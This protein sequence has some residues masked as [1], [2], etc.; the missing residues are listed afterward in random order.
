MIKK[1][2]ATI[3][4]REFSM[5]T[6][7]VA[8]QAS[9]AVW[10][11]MGET[12]VLVTAVGDQGVREGIDFL[13]L[14]VDYQEMSYAAGR[15][16]GNFFRREMGRPSEK[17]TLTSRL[18]DRPVRPRMPKGWTHETQIIATV[19]SVDKVNEPDVM[20]L[21]GA[22][23]ALMISDV[24]FDGPLAGVRV[25]RVDGKLVVNPTSQEIEQSDM[26]FIVAGS[27][28]AIV[29][30]EG[31]GEQLTEEDVLEALWFGHCEMQPL[32][33]IQEELAAAVG[34][35]KR[36]YAKPAEPEGGLLEKVRALVAG[37]LTEILATAPKLERY[38]KVRA[39]KKKAAETLAE[40][41]PG[42]EG[43]I[44]NM[45][46]D[47]IAHDMREMILTEGRRVDG[48][49]HNQVRPI[50][51]EVGVL[52]RAHGS[53]LFTR[54]ET[55]AVVVATLGT[56]GDE[57]R[58]ESVTEGDTFRHFLLH[59]NFPPYCVGEAKMLRGPGRRE[60]GHGALARRALERV[61]PKR[62]D[63]PYSIRVVSEI[64]E[65]NGSS[66]MATVCGGSMALMD[67][68][69]PSRAA[70]AGVA[71]GLIKEGDNTV[72]LTDI[73]GDEDHLGDMDFKVAGTQDGVTAVQMDIKISGIT[74][75]IMGRA[76]DQAREARLH[77]L[78]EMKKSIERARGEISDWAPRITTIKI[79]VERIKDVI[80]PGGKVIRGIQM[81]TGVKID[82]EDDGTVHVAAVDGDAG[83]KALQM[84]RELTQE[85]EEGAVYE[86]T[87]VR[88]MDFGAFVELMPGRD[89]LVHI[90]ELDH[91]RVRA[92]TDVLREGDRVK[93][94]VLGVDDR[95]KI[96]L[97]RKAL[98]PPPEPGEGQEEG[99]SGDD[100]PQREPRSGG[101]R[102]DDRPG[103]GR[104]DRR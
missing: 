86:G 69:V 88:I 37:D 10:V 40:E 74:K 56:S 30:V 5:E 34:K 94:K 1:V 9:G 31:G 58:I 104:N 50:A 75:D 54:G 21:T 39:T 99:S 102:G 61:L 43:K 51:T 45:V 8:K 27:R 62:E 67:A 52:P 18:I 73:M 13:P 71:M 38:G 81:E 17:E 16:P 24:P 68:G 48:R 100:R 26:D 63:F 4:G 42:W 35:P 32:L 92:V 103:R 49:A 29:M 85:V 80:G 33:D 77:I 66:S 28:N 22:S 64:T 60:I 83:A 46:E 6:G 97:S 90:S 55:Q 84:I 2:T 98:L 82:V 101:R 91:T 96:R 89:G 72:V 57:Q 53:A 59:Y 44:K 65:S 41:F 95:G 12:I 76:L 19:M 36:D 23:A 20:A 25:G 79:P 70:V 47:F 15:I 87:V 78:G 7:K 93:V 14:T 3:N 11:T